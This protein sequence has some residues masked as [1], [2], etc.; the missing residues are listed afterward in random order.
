VHQT[1]KSLAISQKTTS[2]RSLS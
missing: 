2:C 1:K